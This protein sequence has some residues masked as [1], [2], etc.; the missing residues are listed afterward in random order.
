VELCK[1]DLTTQ[2]VQ[3]FTEL[4]GIVGGLYA[5]A[6]G[7]PAEVADAIY[8]HYRPAGIED[9]GPRS[10]VGA[11]LSLA[12]KLDTVVSGF[13]AGLA[14]TG[15]SDPFGL[16]R[17]GNGVVKVLVDRAIQIDPWNLTDFALAAIG[18]L[19]SHKSHL[20]QPLSKF[21]VERL[22][23]YLAEGQRLRYDTVRAVL[24][25]R[26]WGGAA[27]LMIPSNAA[28]WAKALESIRD[29]ENFAAIVAAAKRTRS[30]L[31]KSAS[32]ADLAGALA[33]DKAL[34]EQ[35]AEA[36]LFEEYTKA[37]NDLNGRQRTRIEDYRSAL[38][39]IAKLRP[40]VDAFFDNVLVMAEDED[41]RRNR[42]ALL[43]KLQESVFSSFAD[44]SEIVAGTE[45]SSGN[46]RVIEGK[47]V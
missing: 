43:R 25:G 30:I 8:D 40:F 16:R 12:D 15:S 2:M 1:C 22:A 14:P 44:L 46:S 9:S 6:Q 23:Y 47:A 34:L 20:A 38:L 27:A 31:Q 19:P 28:M 35:G 17:A 33:I 32:Q 10:I 45:S 42:L 24:G 29:T 4:Q 5:R 39:E 7:E 13:S 18:Q 3:E 36:S 37:W 11:V 41:L 21:W 26:Q